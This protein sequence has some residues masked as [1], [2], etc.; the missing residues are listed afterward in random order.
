ML[1]TR[2]GAQLKRNIL[3]CQISTI[4]YQIMSGLDT[5]VN[6]KFEVKFTFTTI[7]RIPLN[8]TL[9]LDV[10][11]ADLDF[12]PLDSETYC[13]TSFRSKNCWLDSSK[14]LYVR[15]DQAI[16]ANTAMSVTTFAKSKLRAT[17]RPVS[18][19]I[20]AIPSKPSTLVNTLAP[21]SLLPVTTATTLN[22]AAMFPL[23]IKPLY[24]RTSDPMKPNYYTKLTGSFRT[25]HLPFT[26]LNLLSP[27][28]KLATSN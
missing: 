4:A 28:V 8:S 12:L 13:E 25:A 21:N 7:C 1:T 3:S 9:R 17:I 26:F 27:F 22:N 5:I 16:P 24:E 2:R 14:V 6:G 15:F 11:A 23:L 18:G 19:V 10:A 20:Y